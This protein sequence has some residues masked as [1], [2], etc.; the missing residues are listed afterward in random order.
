MDFVRVVSLLIEMFHRKSLLFLC[1]IYVFLYGCVYVE[2]AAF[3]LSP[4]MSRG[5]EHALYIQMT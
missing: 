2:D 1:Q 3:L 5:M 4:V